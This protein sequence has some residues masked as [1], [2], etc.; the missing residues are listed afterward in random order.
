MPVADDVSLGSMVEIA[1]PELVNIYGCAIGDGTKIG[2]FTEI[3][4]N[5]IIGSRCKISSHTFVCEGV[6]IEDEVFVGHGVVFTND[7]YP[8]ATTGEGVLQTDR[9]WSVVRTTVRSHA[10]IG[11]NSTILAGVTI[12]KGAIVGAGSVITKDIPEFSIA[13]GNPSRTIG[14]VRDRARAKT[15][16]NSGEI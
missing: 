2:P 10:S 7:L 4:K 12:G 13:V 14:D 16:T 8:R 5:A 11:S 1:H 15:P 3:Q 9:D 6:M